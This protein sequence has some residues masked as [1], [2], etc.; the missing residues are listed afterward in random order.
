[1][2]TAAEI[3]RKRAEKTKNLMTK[4]VI[5]A[6]I[7]K[8]KNQWELL[9]K[10]LNLTH[11]LDYNGEI[12]SDPARAYSATCGTWERG[13]IWTRG[14]FRSTHWID[15]LFPTR[16]SAKFECKMRKWTPKEYANIESQYSEAE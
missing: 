13:I 4:P 12:I 11:L 3:W 8:S 16:A 9:D 7:E 14:P 15:N 2:E 6:I 1:M 5:Y 10:K